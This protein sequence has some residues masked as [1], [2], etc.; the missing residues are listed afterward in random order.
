VRRPLSA[1]RLVVGDV[2]E[3]HG[4]QG[5]AELLQ[6]GVEGLRLR[7]V[8]G[9]PSRMKPSAAS[10][11]P[12]RSTIT[13]DDHVVW[14]EV[15]AVHVLLRVLRGGL[16]EGSGLSRTARGRMSAGGVVGQL[17]VLQQPL[18]LGS[19]AGPRRGLGGRD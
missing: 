8:R 13:T 2:D 14:D 15:A 12:S 17:E 6:L 5:P 1:A 10:G 19:L 3:K 18:A 9:K 4:S 7:I 11:S 16:A